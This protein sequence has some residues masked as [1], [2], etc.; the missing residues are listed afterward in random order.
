MPVVP[1]IFGVIALILA[2]VN[3]RS[4]WQMTRGWQYRNREAV[5]PSD[6]A[7]IA[8]RVGL[9]LAGIVPDRDPD[10]RHGV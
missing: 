9:I 8:S 5:E 10:R 2:C 6:A 4:L 7:L 1:I 3:Q